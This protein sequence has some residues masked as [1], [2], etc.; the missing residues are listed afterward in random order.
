MQ[1]LAFASLSGVY[2]GVIYFSRG[3]LPTKKAKKGHLVGGPR[4]AKEPD[5]WTAVV[6]NSLWHCWA[7][8][9]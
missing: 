2:A 8:A 4:E 7:M 3:T 5:G 1:S 6:Q 9:C